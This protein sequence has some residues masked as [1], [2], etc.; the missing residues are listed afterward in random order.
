[1]AKAVTRYQAD[2][3]T[4]MS[5][6]TYDE[7]SVVD[8]QTS[9]P[10][11]AV[12][13][14]T[15][16]EALANLV[17]RRQQ[18]AANDG[19]TMLQIAADANKLSDPATPPS[20]VAIAGTELEVGNYKG[21]VVFYNANGETL[22]STES[23]I[24]T[25]TATNERIRWTIPVGPSGTVGRKVYRTIVGAAGTFKLAETVANN[26]D[27]TVDDDTP[28]ASLGVVEPPAN[29][30]GSAGTWGTADVVIGALPVNSYAACWERYNIPVAT[31]TQGNP[32]QALVTLME[33]A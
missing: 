15:G 21:K 7:G 33:T 16:D 29:S 10:R 26:V 32:R 19:W 2:F 8:G 13:K 23:G 17:L 11:R 20:G 28:D 30:T 1:M 5:G 12:W 22:A 3:R 6:S 31:T 18:V 25:T 4:L 9:T 14:N 27:T 24:V